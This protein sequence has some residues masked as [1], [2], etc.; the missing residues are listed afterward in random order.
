[1]EAFFQRDISRQILYLEGE[2]L[3]KHSL[4]E[5]IR[6]HAGISE[7]IRKDLYAFLISWF[8]E[9][10]T[11]T[12]QTSGSTGTPKMMQVSK[13]GMMNSACRTCRFLGLHEGDSL[14]LSMNLKYIGAQ[15]MIVRALVAGLDV[16]LRE[17]AA[18]PL[19]TLEQSV[20]FLSMVPMQLASS[21]QKGSERKLL[22][23]ARVVLVG[24]GAVDRL[25][26]EELQTLACK[27]YSTYGMTET[28]SHIAMRCLNGPERSERYYPLEGVGLSLSDRETLV[29]DVPDIC[30]E[31]LETNDRAV[32]YPDGSFVIKGRADNVINSG[33]IKIQIEEDEARLQGVLPFPFVLTSVSDIFYGEKV[34]LLAECKEDQFKEKSWFTILKEVL[35]QYHAP[36]DIFFIN[37]IPR[38]ENGKVDRKACK[39]LAQKQAD[40]KKG[41]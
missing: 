14:L 26:E 15:M 4:S 16:R 21:L 23:A 22:N 34:V 5:L 41:G 10:E 30:G 6:R 29:I 40:T 27:V 28:L 38:T 19:A 3:D 36:R 31:S 7:G 39:L 18:H 20:D 17:P 12:V 9:Q 25:L 33:G 1:M 32:I 8:S 13:Q 37:S 2:Q 11:M 24:G 35:P